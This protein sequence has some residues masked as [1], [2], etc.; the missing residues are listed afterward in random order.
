VRF[1]TPDGSSLVL[2][3]MWLPTW[4]GQNAQ[5]KKELEEALSPEL[6]GKE[7]SDETLDYAHSRVIEVICEKFPLDGL[8]DY[9]DGVK[10]LT[11]E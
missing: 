8:R 7:M 3:Y 10:F 6:R 11:Q 9:L 4:L 5:L 1:V 2:N